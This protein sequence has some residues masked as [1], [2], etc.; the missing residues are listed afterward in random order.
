MGE[1]GHQTGRQDWCS[2]KTSRR[3]DSG[4]RPSLAPPSPRMVR[5]RGHGNSHRMNSHSWWVSFLVCL[6]VEVCA[7]EKTKGR[8][9]L[10]SSLSFS[11]DFV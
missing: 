6:S 3:M 1:R 2:G 8:G 7:V 5:P 10:G 4:T 9:G 11:A